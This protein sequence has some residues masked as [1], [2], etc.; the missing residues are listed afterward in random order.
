MENYQ[1]VFIFGEWTGSEIHEVTYELLNEGRRLADELNVPLGVIF[2][3]PEEALSQAKELIFYGAD[4]VLAALYPEL[5]SFKDDLYAQI[6]A[7]IIQEKKP[8]VMLFPATSMGQA[9]APRVAGLLKLGL[10]AHCIA[11]EIRQEDRALIQIR[12]SFGE[13]IMARITS[14]TK[15]QM[16]TVRP[17]VFPAAKKDE[18][19]TGEFIKYEV[20]EKL[21]QSAIEIVEKRPSDKPEVD[22][23][24]AQV[25]VAG[26]RGLGSKEL[27]GKLFEL[28]ELLDGAVGATRPVCHLGWAS[29]DHMIGVSGVN[30]SPKLYIGFGISGALH[31][32]VG[33]QGVDTLVAVNI[34]KEAPLMKR[35]DIA[36]QADVKEVLPLFIKKLKK[37]K[38]QK[39]DD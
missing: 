1:G 8:E 25:I 13:E 16:A 4:I 11:F 27:F 26:G 3:G 32:M 24:R 19:R 28:A 35:A 34:D 10:T 37:L 18:T 30:V 20:P 38:S 21:R 33:L 23:T 2:L 36:V 9:V 7:H 22:I 12:P 31:H 5:S 39:E 6:V 14:R 15:P 29:E 17:G